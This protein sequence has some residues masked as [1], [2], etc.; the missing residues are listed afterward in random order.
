MAK[1]GPDKLSLLRSPA[2]CSLQEEKGEEGLDIGED[3]GEEGREEQQRGL[4][5]PESSLTSL[6]LTRLNKD[7]TGEGRAGGLCASGSV[8]PSAPGPGKQHS[9]P[10]VRSGH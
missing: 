5:E 6:S 3:G 8:L 2:M 4:G 9:Q 10:A 1:S 7:F